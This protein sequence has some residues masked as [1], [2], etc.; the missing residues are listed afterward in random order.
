MRAISRLLLTLSL[1]GL[2]VNDGFAEVKL[3]GG[4][5]LKGT[6]T[7]RPKKTESDGSAFFVL[8]SSSPTGNLGGMS[9]ASDTCYSD[10]S[11]NNWKG[12][13][14]AGTLSAGRVKAFLCS[15]TSNCNQLMSDMTYNFAV[16]G[17]PNV[18]GA[19]F[20][21]SS[22]GYGPRDSAD[23]SGA[24]YFGASH[25]YRTGRAMGTTT[26]WANGVSS[27]CSN[28]GSTSGTGVVGLSDG[29]DG[30]RWNNGTLSCASNA[31]L[32]C[33]VDPYQLS[34]EVSGGMGV[35]N[36]VPSGSNSPGGYSPGDILITVIFGL[37][38]FTEVTVPPAGWARLEKAGPI[39]IP[40]RTPPPSTF[41][42]KFWPRESRD[43]IA[44]R[45]TERTASPF[46]LPA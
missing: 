36:G 19:S 28:W 7:A 2:P 46:I 44:G 14:R 35:F 15:S 5:R 24:G 9:G 11:L 31:K 26:Q 13:D 3:K 23:W 17:D 39:S 42:I 40:G 6:V 20:T 41:G 22:S 4:V 32:I 33:F 29:P 12:K 1:L 18:G 34:E 38:P 45:R 10:L 30:G 16:A 21:T 8:S 37:S 27:Q 25:T 43:P